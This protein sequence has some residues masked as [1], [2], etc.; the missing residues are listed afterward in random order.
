MPSNPITNAKK[1]ASKL[2]KERDALVKSANKLHLFISVPTGL[3]GGYKMLQKLKKQ[4]N[5]MQE[6]VS[7]LDD[8]IKI[9]ED[10]ISKPVAEKK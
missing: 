7:T 3:I 6:L 5:L 10:F 1:L 4:S 9:F 8:R 2:S